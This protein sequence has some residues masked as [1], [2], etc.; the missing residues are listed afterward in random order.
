MKGMTGAAVTVNKPC[1]SLLFWVKTA[2]MSSVF[3][4]CSGEGKDFDDTTCSFSRVGHSGMKSFANFDRAI[5]WNCLRKFAGVSGFT[6]GI[7]SQATG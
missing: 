2:L 1:P 6:T 5:T 3:P 7:S 4:S